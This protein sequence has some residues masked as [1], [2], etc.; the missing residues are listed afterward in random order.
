[1]KLKIFCKVHFTVSRKGIKTH[2]QGGDAILEE[3]NKSGKRFKIGVPSESQW[4]RVFR[5]LDKLSEVWRLFYS[6]FISHC[7][8]IP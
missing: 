3:I 6:S 4:K 8:S 2:R 7:T 1:M 5:S